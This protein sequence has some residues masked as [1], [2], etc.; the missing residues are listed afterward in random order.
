MA[1]RDLSSPDSPSKQAHNWLAHN[2]PWL[3]NLLGGRIT[4][5]LHHFEKRALFQIDRWTFA[6]FV[7]EVAADGV[8]VVGEGFCGEDGYE[9]SHDD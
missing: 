8:D 9:R 1:R 7:L 4:R 3:W 5:V 2:H 6:T